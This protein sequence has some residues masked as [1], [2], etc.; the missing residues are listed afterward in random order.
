MARRSVWGRWACRP[1]LPGPP[2]EGEGARILCL[3][4][5]RGG[6]IRGRGRFW[7]GWRRVGGFMGGGF[8]WGGFGRAEYREGGERQMANRKS[9]MA[10]KRRSRG[11]GRVGSSATPPR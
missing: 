6:G 2:P 1:P 10:K 4:F 3:I 8:R 7:R 5:R 11:S 9:Q